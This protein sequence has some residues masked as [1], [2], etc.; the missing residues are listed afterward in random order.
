M[1][2]YKIAAN[3]GDA[4]A[5]HNIGVLYENGQG[6]E[7]SYDTAQ[8]WYKKARNNGYKGNI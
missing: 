7:A 3:L 1:K 5:M 2:Y 6:V 4:T 8:Y